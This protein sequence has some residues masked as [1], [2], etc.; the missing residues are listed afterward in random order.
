[1]MP[2]H[3]LTAAVLTGIVPLNHIP[4]DELTVEELKN[5]ERIMNP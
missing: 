5:L 3:L 4:K 2:R 1:M